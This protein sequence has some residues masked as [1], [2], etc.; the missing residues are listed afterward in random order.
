MIGRFP[1][2]RWTRFATA[3]TLALSLSLLISLAPVSATSTGRGSFTL[4]GQAQGKLGLNGALSCRAGVGGWVNPGT[5]Q[6]QLTMVLVDHGISPRADHWT[7]ELD[8][9]RHG[10]SPLSGAQ[11]S[12]AAALDVTHG[13]YLVEG[14][15]ADS[16]TITVAADW[17]SGSVSLVLPP[18]PQKEGGAA[19]KTVTVRGSWS[20]G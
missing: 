11:S 10:R 9:L 8:V 12:V 4:T 5:G 15:L 2:Q 7:L 18:K 14:W 20:C 1:A 3:A 6:E 17:K 19:K 16:G 13:D